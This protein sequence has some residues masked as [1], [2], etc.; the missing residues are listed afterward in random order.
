MRHLLSQ[1]LR[2]IIGATLRKKPRVS[3]QCFIGNHIGKVI[4]CYLGVD[5]TR[6]VFFIGHGQSQIMLAFYIVETD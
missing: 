6:T 1:L 5:P 3:I 2:Q 4:D